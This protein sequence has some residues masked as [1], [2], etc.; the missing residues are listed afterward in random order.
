MKYP[1]I[2]EKNVICI[3]SKGRFGYHSHVIYQQIPDGDNHSV[4]YSPERCWFYCIRPYD[5]TAFYSE[6][7]IKL[8]STSM[9]WDSRDFMLCYK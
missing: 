3:D 2:L 5:N 8:G 6:N 9:K 7:H 1:I 4:N